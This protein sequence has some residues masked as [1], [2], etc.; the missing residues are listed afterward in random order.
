MK[1]VLYVSYFKSPKVDGMKLVELQK[2]G[3]ELLS[4]ARGTP[5][6]YRGKSLICAMPTWSL[7]NRFRGNLMSNEEY[8]Y[9]YYQELMSRQNSIKEHLNDLDSGKAYI[10][11]CHCGP[12]KFCHR[13]LWAN[14]LNK[15][16]YEVK[17]L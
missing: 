11:L 13:H 8:S 16:G 15:L 1:K 17:E 6:Y 3:Y 4:I 9:C 14:F 2:E 7:I 5:P 10:Y 12:T